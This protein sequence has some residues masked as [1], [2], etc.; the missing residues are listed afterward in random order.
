MVAAEKEFVGS[1]PTTQ[2][3]ILYRSSDEE[4]G[5]FTF[6]ITLLIM[7]GILLSSSRLLSVSDVPECS[8]QRQ[9]YY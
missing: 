2:H 1:I 4:V 5:I 6:G 8:K 9:H 3:V 7:L